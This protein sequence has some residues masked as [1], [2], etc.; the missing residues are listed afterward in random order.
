M[1][2]SSVADIY[3]ANEE[4][5]ARLVARVESLDESAQN[6]RADEAAWTVA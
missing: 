1:L 3:R 4:V 6:Y 2:Y 5:R